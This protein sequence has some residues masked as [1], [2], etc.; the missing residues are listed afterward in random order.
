MAVAQKRRLRT[1]R[2]R[3]SHL[4]YAQA[5]KLLGTNGK[6]MLRQGGRWLDN[7]DL[8]RDVYLR[9][10]L[11][12]LILRPV[13]SQDAP[14]RITITQKGD[15]RG[16]LCCNCDACAG[17]CEHVAAALSLI[18]EEKF[19]LGLSD[20]PKE[21]KPLELLGESDLEQRAIAERA[22]LREAGAFSNDLPESPGALDRLCCD[23]SY[24]GQDVPRGAARRRAGRF[25]LFVPGLPSQYVGHVQAHHLRP[26]TSQDAILRST[27]SRRPP[28]IVLRCSPPLR[29]DIE[30]R[31]QPPD[32]ISTHRK[33]QL[34]GL[35][36]QPIE[37]VDGLLS[38]IRTL[39][40]AGETVVIYPDAEEWIQQRLHDKN[41]AGLVE[42]IRAKPAK[43][44]LRTTLLKSPLLPYQLD[45][46]GF[47]VGAGRAILADDM[48]LGKTIQGIGVA[49]LLSQVDRH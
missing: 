29:A 32:K 42:E 37:D 33:R 40:R 14:V 46:I 9:G 20:I 38:A 43:H 22:R 15:H 12:R 25:V 41:L 2:D 48:G 28:T 4:S 35:L 27:A 10:D 7:V 18:L 1:L 44:P 26:A 24:V 34:S 39:E 13:R 30:L 31:L 19:P 47:A 5:C 45:G 36:D 23:E 3:L 6:A 49:E 8:D 21:G 17:T 16:R 11:F